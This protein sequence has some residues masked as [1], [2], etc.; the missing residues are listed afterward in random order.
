[1]QPPCG[2]DGP[3]Q[4]VGRFDGC[5][6]NPQIASSATR[7]ARS[8]LSGMANNDEDRYV[9]KHDDGWA[10]KKENAKRASN[11]YD[12]QAEAVSRARQIVDRP[13]AGWVRYACRVRTGSS[14]TATPAGATRPGPK[15]PADFDAATRVVSAAA[16]CGAG[17]IRGNAPYAAGA[18]GE[19]PYEPKWDV[20]DGHPT[21][22]RSTFVTSGSQV[23]DAPHRVSD[24]DSRRG[25]LNGT[26][27]T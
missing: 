11:V 18:S 7:G 23:T 4:H 20:S 22:A 15:T 17:A 25:P 24:S 12:T 26:L 19:W 16:W 27:D 2:S 3:R 8:S 21:R 14:A 9:V 10:V 5:Q 1:M 13:A 6:M